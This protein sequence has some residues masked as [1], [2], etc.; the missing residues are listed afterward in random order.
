MNGNKNVD[1]GFTLAEVLITLGIIGVVAALTMPQ[2]I[3]NYKERQR[4]TQLKKAYSVLQQAFTMAVKDYGTPNYWDLAKT[5]TGETDKDGNNILDESGVVKSMNILKQYLKQK[6]IPEGEY[7]GYV[8]SLDGRQAEW[9]WKVESDKY[10]YLADGTIVAQGWISSPECKQTFDGCGDFWVFFP[11]KNK[12]MKIGVDVFNFLFTKRGFV[13][14]GMS[15][16]PSTTFKIACDTKNQSGLSASIQGRACTAWVL[17][18]ENMDYLH[19]NDLDWN[20]KSKCK[21]KL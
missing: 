9:P 1:K 3:T 14:K 12:N 16:E 21:Q 11:S 17:Y 6:K 7:I 8:R 15:N 4:V 2:L 19:C 13:P 20:T 5:D 10:V 18:N